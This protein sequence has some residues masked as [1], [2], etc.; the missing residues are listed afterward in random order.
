MID[1]FHQHEQQEHVRIGLVSPEQISAWATKILP[2]GERVGEVTN[3]STFDYQTKKPIKGGLF[4]ERIFGP[5][6]SGICACGNSRRSGDKKEDHNF[7]EQCGV[8]FVDSRIRRYQMG[9][10][11]LEY[12]VLH[13]WYWKRRPSYILTLLDERRKDLEKLLSFEFCIARPRAK[14]PMCIRLRGLVEARMEIWYQSLLDFFPPQIFKTIKRREVSTGAVAIR[15]LLANLNLAHCRAE[16]LNELTALAKIRPTGDDWEDRLVE[17]RKNFLRRRIQ[18]VER[19]R[20]NNIKPEWMV[21]TLLPV[22]PP[23]L[24]PILEIEGGLFI[25]SDSNILYRDVIQANK[26]I[27][28]WLWMSSLGLNDSYDIYRP[29]R[30][31]GLND[32]DDIS[33]N[34]MPAESIRAL[35]IA[36]DRLLQYGRGQKPTWDRNDRV[37]KSFTQVIQGKEGRFRHTLL[38]K[39]VDYS[40]RSVIVVGPTLSLHEC[41]LPREMAIQLFQTFLIRRLMLK[42]IASNIGVA[43]KLIRQNEPTVWKI[44]EEVVEGYPVLLNRAPTLHRFGIQAFLPILVEERAICLHPLVCKG[45]NADFDGDTMAV[46]VPLSFEAQAEAHLLMFAHL[47]LL[48]PAMGD[49]ICV[50]TQDMLMGLYVLTRGNRRGICAH[51]WNPWNSKNYENERIDDNNSKYRKEGLFCN[52]YDAVAAYRQK[53]IRFDSPLWVRWVRLRP[54]SY[55]LPPFLFLRDDRPLWAQCLL[56]RMP[57]KLRRTPDM[58]Q[59]PDKLHL[60]SREAPIEVHYESL[61]TSHAIYRNYLIIRNRIDEIIYIRTTVGHISLSREIEHAIQDYKNLPS[62]SPTSISYIL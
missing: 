40:G 57:D 16:S 51:R 34:E 1:Q 9:Y 59:T 36:V 60:L 49:P 55:E 54:T 43:K 53:R 5:I 32:S 7:C 37:F 46:H 22:L 28:R 3:T 20:Q 41:G 8:E 61:G 4:C 19:L 14:R 25:S 15:E 48:S 33:L 47:N 21:L 52:S 56:R 12:P 29:K 6:K 31:L 17:G 23:E 44:L 39:R 24:R 58:R 18:L 62:S 30:S 45:F 42:K 38:G 11:K 50:P 35:E 13:V 10:I 2:N 27:K 26:T